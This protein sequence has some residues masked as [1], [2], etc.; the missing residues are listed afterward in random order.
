MANAYLQS[1][2]KKRWRAAEPDNTWAKRSR[3][4][5]LHP[6]AYYEAWDVFDDHEAARLAELKRQWN[7]A[8]AETTT[9]GHLTESG[10]R[11]RRTQPSQTIR[12]DPQVLNAAGLP[13]G[14]RYVID[15]TTGQMVRSSH[16]ARRDRRREE[17]R[18]AKHAAKV[19]AKEGAAKEDAAKEGANKEGT[20][21]KGAA[22]EG[23]AKEGAS[24]TSSRPSTKSPATSA[25]HPKLSTDDLVIDP[26]HGRLV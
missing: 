25:A 2:L 4:D 1:K 13:V 15:E 10:G 8:P 19:A 9:V 6:P 12:I 17:K 14:K 22:K 18:A 26:F 20:A 24:S 23:A 21:K 11:E 16:A 7:T 3:A 5:A